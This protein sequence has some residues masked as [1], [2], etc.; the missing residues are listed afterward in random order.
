MNNL[1]A[2]QAHTRTSRHGAA[3]PSKAMTDDADLISYLLL[4]RFGADGK[5][6]LS[7]PIL[8]Y[9]SIAKLV[10]KPV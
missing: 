5:A 7:Q 6:N 3:G 4:L 1:K 2:K 9:T 10:K 8:N